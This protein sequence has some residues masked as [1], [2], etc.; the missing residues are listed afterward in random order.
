MSRRLAQSF[1]TVVGFSS[2]ATATCFSV[3]DELQTAAAGVKDRRRM[4]YLA[5]FDKFKGSIS[6]N[7]A[8]E[9]AVAALGGG[10]AGRIVD[11][12]PLT[13]GGEG[14]AQ[15]LTGAA[16]GSL[17]AIQVA[18]PRG[19]TVAASLGIV[20]SEKIPSAARLRMGLAQEG[21]RV[22][23][24]EMAAA[25]G[26]EL[27]SPG[28]RDPF[29]TTSQGTGELVE[30]AARQG[31]DA[32]LLGVGGSATHDLGLGALG[33][34]GLAYVSDSGNAIERIVP[35]DWPWLARITGRLV[36]PLPPIFIACD[37]AN[38]LLGPTGAA[39]VYGPQK[40]L[41]HGD[42]ARIER[43][44]AKVSRL[45]CRHFERP[46]SLA[47]EPGAGA[48]G[49]IAFGLMAA[50]GA[51]LLPG[52]DLVAAWLDLDERLAAADVVL[53]GEGRFDESSLSGKGPATLA[54]RALAL[55][56]TVHVFAGQ[57]ANVT[58]IPGL[59]VHEISP[60]GM[61]IDE[62]LAGAPSLLE[63]AIRA[64]LPRQ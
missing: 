54:R 53:T 45:L 50:A 57:V 20:H 31:V 41:R 59:S 39:A 1:R 15:I 5:A 33:A 14:F 35:A 30:A 8:C 10:T 61:P 22:G 55:G 63:A 9:V 43:G 25:S 13:D 16:G 3:G 37:V 62:A 47:R 36:S 27:L 38:P 11:A 48:A 34:L 44:S 6:A 40:G 56:K 4:R 58:Q 18:G 28:A 19:A 23:V 46:E 42:Y 51:R 60:R 7:R 29:Y 49:G 21:A 26:L 12:C 17:S 32:I 52:F 64:S 2:K 24:V